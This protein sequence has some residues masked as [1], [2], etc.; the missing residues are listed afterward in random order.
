MRRL[1]A[2]VDLGVL[3]DIISNV[4]GMM[5]LLACVA[6]LVQRQDAATPHGRLAAKPISYPLTY[7]PEK[8][9]ITY[10]LKNRKF[11]RLPETQLL[12]EVTE[13]TRTGKP[14]MWVELA[15]DG[16]YGR[17]HVTPTATGFRFQFRT[18]QDGGIPLTDA[19]ELTKALDEEVEKYPPDKFFYVFHVWP[20]AFADFREIRE[21]LLQRR[22]EVGWMPRSYER[23][24]PGE[25]PPFDITY[26]IGMYDEHYTSI[27]AQ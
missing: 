15:K 18:N 16:V 8:R 21:F 5:I 22:V 11:Y 23:P 9:S 19:T 14:V 4:A 24:D 12:E 3:V 10:C 20:D 6:L 13:R 27:K 7:L 17:I 1:I 25:P 26:A 2:S